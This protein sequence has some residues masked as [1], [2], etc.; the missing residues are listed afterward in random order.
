MLFFKWNKIYW[1]KHWK[2]IIN[3]FLKETIIIVYENDLIESFNLY[4]LEG[5]PLYNLD[6]KNKE[7]IINK[8]EKKNIDES[9]TNKNRKIIFCIL[10]NSD[11][12]LIII[13]DD[14]QVK[15][16]DVSSLILKKWKILYWL[17]L[18]W[19]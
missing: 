1:I 7:D 19:I 14:N 11:N 16:E 13:Y 18:I 3:Y 10:G 5:F 17:S 6:L 4:E 15:I 12:K 8:K 9:E 2:K